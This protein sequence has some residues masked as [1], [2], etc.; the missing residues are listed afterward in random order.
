MAYNTAAGLWFPCHAVRLDGTQGVNANLLI[1][2]H[3]PKQASFSEEDQKWIYLI[4]K[5]FRQ[6]EKVFCFL[7]LFTFSCHIFAENKTTLIMKNVTT[8][9]YANILLDYW[10]KRSFGTEINK[11]LMILLLREIIPEADVQ[12]ITYG[13]KEHP[14]PFPDSHGVIFDIECTSADGSR[15][16][17]EVQLAQQKWFMERALYYSSF[18]IQEQLDKGK[19][20]YEFM[21]VYFIGLM[22]FTLHYD[23]DGR[24]LFRYELVERDSGEPMTDRLKSRPKEMQA[25][26]FELLFNSAEIAKFT[27]EEKVKYEHDMTTDRDIRNQIAFS[28]EEGLKEG[29]EKGMEKGAREALI[30]MAKK[31][32]ANGN[33]S[34]E[35]IKELTG[36]LPSEYSDN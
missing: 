16:I 24:F 7:T 31:M 26:I 32:V 5:L 6:K 33:Y 11:R 35:Q 8:S 18:A 13:N 25:E 2:S 20:T 3:L 14:N 19:D 21:P 10:F 34:E 22:D 12:E 30:E 1:I 28:R 36:L 15:F 4:T 9:R 27:P 29:L 17:V 23:T